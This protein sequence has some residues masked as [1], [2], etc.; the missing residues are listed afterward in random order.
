MVALDCE[1]CITAKGFELTRCSLVG[2]DGGVLLD[3]LVLPHNPI[4]DYNTR[5]SGI[6]GEMLHGCTTR[7][8]DVQ[9]RL[10][11]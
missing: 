1:M 2:E 9:V 4:T 7:L 3:T 5:Y 6:T 8:E 10:P 11:G